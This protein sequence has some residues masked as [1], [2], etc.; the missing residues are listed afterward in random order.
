MRLIYRE[1]HEPKTEASREQMCCHYYCRDPQNESKT[2][3]KT[4]KRGSKEINIMDA[5]TSCILADDS[6]DF[7][8][9]YSTKSD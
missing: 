9:I 8:L 5:Y 2:K 3:T 7:S 1:T 6:F 4:K